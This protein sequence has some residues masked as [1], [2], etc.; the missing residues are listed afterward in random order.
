MFEVDG[1]SARVYSVGALYLEASSNIRGA[2]TSGTAA[3][4][5]QGTAKAGAREVACD[6]AH[7]VQENLCFLAKLFLDHKTLQFDVEPFLFY[8]L[9]EV[10]YCCRS[11]L[12]LRCCS[13]ANA[14]ALTALW[15]RS[16]CA[17]CGH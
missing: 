1:K 7:V 9:T 8:V 6:C 14:A 3:A 13:Y 15:C 11:S 5:R 4:V 17:F 12:S 16:C 2:C 10:C